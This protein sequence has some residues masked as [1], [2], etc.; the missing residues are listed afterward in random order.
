MR[1]GRE[2]CGLDPIA[3]LRPLE[4]PTISLPFPRPSK[5]G[6][7]GKLYAPEQV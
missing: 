7:K 6:I 3:I 2:E 1:G 4:G 5:E